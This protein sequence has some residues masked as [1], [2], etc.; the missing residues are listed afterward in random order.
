MLL[1]ARLQLPAL[2]LGKAPWLVPIPAHTA[3]VSLVASQLGGEQGELLH[4]CK[5]PTARSQ[6]RLHR[7]KAGC[8]SQ[9]G[10]L[11]FGAA[12]M[13]VSNPTC[14]ISSGVKMVIRF[15]FGQRQANGGS[16]NSS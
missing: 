11:W 9:I 7:G 10:G 2:L 6:L 13:Q 15:I 3:S 1:R 14:L 5:E 16:C 4:A 12:T 8:S